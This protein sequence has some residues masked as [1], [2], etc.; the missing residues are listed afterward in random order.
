MNIF[1][2]LSVT[3]IAKQSGDFAVLSQ[4]DMHVLALAYG[5]D[6]LDKEREGK[7]KDAEKTQPAVSS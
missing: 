6:R 4:P 1:E 2:K 3:V 5:L 7:G